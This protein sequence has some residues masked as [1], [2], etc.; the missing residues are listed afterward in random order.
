MGRV[1]DETGNVYGRLTAEERVKVNGK[2]KWKCHCSC[3]NTAYVDGADLR[4][5]HTQSC[6]CY[7]KD[8][9]SE[10]SLRDLSGQTFGELEVLE[11]DMNYYGKRVPVHWFCKCKACGTVKSIST[12]S[13]RRGQISCGCLNSKGEYKIAKL[14]NEQNISFIKE[15]TFADYPKRRYDFAILNKNNEVV[16]LIEFDGIQHFYKPSEW[17]WSSTMTLE[18][19]QE[20]DKEKNQIAKEK[21]IAIIRIPYWRLDTLTLVQLLDDTFLIKEDE[22]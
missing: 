19:Q 5:G 15:F 7:N 18:E 4:R 10:T 12:D 20:R 2:W 6:G 16:R 22:V 17:L 21:N 11:R 8:R 3:G 1:I 9:I 13:L 14:L